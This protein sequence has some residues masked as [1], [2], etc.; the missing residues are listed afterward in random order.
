MLIR[1]GVI[2][3]VV[4]MCSVGLQVLPRFGLVMLLS[5]LSVDKTLHLRRKY[6]YMYK[7]NVNATG[8]LNTFIFRVSVTIPQQICISIS[9]TNRFIF[10]EIVR[11]SWI[12]RVYKTRCSF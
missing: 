9:K 10:R 4:G 7:R 11:N 8:C 6:V 2:I 5:A 3:N 1:C 12:R